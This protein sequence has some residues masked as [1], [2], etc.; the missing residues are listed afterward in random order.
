MLSLDQSVL[1]FNQKDQC[2][3][4]FRRL[5]HKKG[6]YRLVCKKSLQPFE[7]VRNVFEE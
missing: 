5:N 2:T 6:L 4:F 3:R 7:M 1:E